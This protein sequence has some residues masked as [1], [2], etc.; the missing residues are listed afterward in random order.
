M[1][2]WNPIKDRHIKGTSD[3][4]EYWIRTSKS[5]KV[6]ALYNITNVT[7]KWFPLTAEEETV[8]GMKMFAEIL[9]DTTKFAIELEKKELV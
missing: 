1:I 9:Y 7:S 2:N 4:G 5:G 3:L 6:T 8:D